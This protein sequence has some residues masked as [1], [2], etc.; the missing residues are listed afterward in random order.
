MAPS[1]T[2][3]GSAQD[4][5]QRLVSLTLE[6]LHTEAPLSAEDL[7]QRVEGYAPIANHESFRRAFERDKDTLRELGVPIIVAE[8]PGSDPPVDGYRIDRDAYY[9]DIADLA[10]D[11]LEALHLA[12]T[13][14]PVG[15]GA[16]TGA[17][18]RLGGV[19]GTPVGAAPLTR[20]PVL[21]ALSALFSAVADHATVTFAYRGENRS[22]DPYRLDFADGRWYLT[23]NDHDCGALRHFRVDRIDGDVAVGAGGAFPAPDEGAAPAP[24]AAWEFEA[25]PP[26]TAELDV[27]AGHTTWVLA[28][29][30][31]RATVVRRPDGSARI[32]LEVTNRE[33]FRWLALELLDH[34]EVI[35][36]PELRSDVV[37]WLEALT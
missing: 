29:V 9:L 14:I 5:S 33:A 13:L 16:G 10:T 18:W 21:P 20:V 24:G 32:T 22:V 15:D 3:H 1:E 35:G 25:D 11:E 36:P 23:G 2:G 17:L 31:E 28:Q 27:D 19:V 34:G 37:T 7:R 6:L 26:V 12:A 4:R 8:V 30:G